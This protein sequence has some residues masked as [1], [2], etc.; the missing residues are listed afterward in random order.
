MAP[1]QGQAGAREML[2]EQLRKQIEDTAGSPQMKAMLEQMLR[3][4][5]N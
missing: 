3:E 1:V 2:R 5:D 4:L